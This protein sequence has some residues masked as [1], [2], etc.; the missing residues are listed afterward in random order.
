[1]L[2]GGHNCCYIGT[3]SRL[4]QCGRCTR[5]MPHSRKQ[6]TR[7]QQ[8]HPQSI[9][10]PRMSPG[11]CF[12]THALTVLQ[13]SIQHTQLAAKATLV[14]TIPTDYTPAAPLGPK[15]K[16]HNVAAA[17]TTQKEIIKTRCPSHRA[18]P[19]QRPSQ[20]HTL[21]AP[22]A[23]VRAAGWTGCRASRRPAQR[24]RTRRRWGRCRRCA[25]RWGPRQS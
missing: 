4:L 24:R 21:T 9:H 2:V 15:S 17:A 3:E 14:C 22:Q 16:L 13:I 23:G 10:S 20:A 18:R 19:T 8:L 5:V 25:T 6:A 7:A 11:V 12:S 1:V